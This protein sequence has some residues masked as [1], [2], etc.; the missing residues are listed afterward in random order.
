MRL[1]IAVS[2]VRL[3]PWAPSNP[4][5]P[6]GSGGFPF[7]GSAEEAALGTLPGQ[8]ETYVKG[9]APRSDRDKI[10]GIVKQVVD[11]L[12]K[13]SDDFGPDL[14]DDSGVVYNSDGSTSAA[15]R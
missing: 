2:V 15:V 9:T 7:A 5:E 1:K 10:I 4:L 8:W 3:R 6:K 13:E 12:I 11:P 14:L